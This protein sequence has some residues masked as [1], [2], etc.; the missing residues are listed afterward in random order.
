MKSNI[1]IWTIEEKY[2]VYIQKTIVVTANLA[3]VEAKYFACKEDKKE[4]NIF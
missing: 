4:R 2:L 1:Y 3:R